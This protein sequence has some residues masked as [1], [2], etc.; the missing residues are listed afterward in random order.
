MAVCEACGGECPDG[1]AFCG[2]CGHRLG[3]EPQEP[4]VVNVRVGASAWDSFWSC[5]ST[6]IGILVLFFLAFWLFSC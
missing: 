5:L 6:A 2:A 1:A 3:S 4:V